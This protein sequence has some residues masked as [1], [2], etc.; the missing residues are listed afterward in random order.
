M[1]IFFEIKK[2]LRGAQLDG[3]HKKI[4]YGILGGHIFLRIRYFRIK[5]CFD[6][7]D[8]ISDLDGPI[9]LSNKNDNNNFDGLMKDCKECYTSFSF[10]IKFLDLL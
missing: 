9:I 1:D 8:L 4:E 3:G 10:I 6:E 7:S 5:R 2:F